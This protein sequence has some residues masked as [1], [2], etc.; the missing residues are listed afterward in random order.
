M[1]SVTLAYNE[2]FTFSD[3]DLEAYAHAYAGGLERLP[4]YDTNTYVAMN[5]L[6]KPEQAK[7]M[8]PDQIHRSWYYMLAKG[9]QSPHRIWCSP[10]K[11]KDDF[12]NNVEC[13]ACIGFLTDQFPMDLDGHYPYT[14]SFNFSGA[15]IDNAPAILAELVKAVLEFPREN[16]PE[17]WLRMQNEGSVKK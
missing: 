7:N 2:M 5:L 6:P 17:G 10:G 14:L 11:K 13:G 15:D 4:Q 8:T 12:P 9:A 16:A 1:S 3:E